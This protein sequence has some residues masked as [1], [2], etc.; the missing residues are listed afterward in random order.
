M[1]Q[2]ILKY[3]CSFFITMHEW[4][5]LECLKCLRPTTFLKKGVWH[6]CFPMNF[7]KFLRALF[8]KNISNGYFFNHLK[9][10][11]MLDS[12]ACYYNCSTTWRPVCGSNHLLYSN[13]CVLQRA[14]CKQKKAI[15][16]VKTYDANDDCSSKYFLWFFFSQLLFIWNWNLPIFYCNIN[17]YTGCKLNV[18]KTFNLRPVS[19]G[20]VL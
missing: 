20:I 9:F 13:E 6:R 1:L 2:R 5:Y 16:P 15:I 11:L 7:A 10:I 3:V 8:L 4:V 12:N 14:T 17:L 18:Q 19:R